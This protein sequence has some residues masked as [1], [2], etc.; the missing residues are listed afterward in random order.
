MSDQL[1]GVLGAI[2]QTAQEGNRRQRRAK[3]TTG[4]KPVRYYKGPSADHFQKGRDVL[5]G[6]GVKFDD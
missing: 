3:E 6:L 2:S 1:A 5:A 4:E